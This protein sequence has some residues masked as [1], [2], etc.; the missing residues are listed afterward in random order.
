M[1]VPTQD[2]NSACPGCAERDREIADLKTRVARLE[3]GARAGKRQ[4]APFS[5]G[6]PKA[7]PKPP[8]R[9][10]G[11]DHGAH[12]HRDVPSRIDEVYD[13]PLPTCCSDT[14]CP[15]KVRLTGVAQQY[16]TEIIR[17]SVNRQ[18]NVPVGECDACHRRVQGRHPLQTSDA[19]GAAASQV[20]PDAQALIVQL[21]KE[22]GLSH[23]KVKRF[24]KAAFDM[25]L[26][27]GG[28]C[29]AMLR[30]GRRCEPAYR[31]IVRR[32]RQSSFI[33]PDETGWR[34]GGVLAWLHVA[35]GAD[36]TAYL[37]HRHRGYEAAAEL[38]GADYEGSLTHDGWSA[39]EQFVYAIH[40]TCLGHLLR[41]SKELEE[42]A[43][44]VAARACFPLAVKAVLKEALA[45]RDRRDAGELT[46]E[47]AREQAG[48]LS[49]RVVALVTPTQADADNERFAKHLWNQQ[50]AL[51]T[52]LEYGGVDATNH[53]AEQAIR[54]AVPNRK[55]SGGNRTEAGAEAQSILTSVLRT[56]VQRGI[57]S[58]SFISDTLKACLGRHP[59]IVPETG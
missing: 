11:E 54:P 3:A 5:K 56:T 43:A 40:Q 34:I 27:R 31:A 41:R 42:A 39:Y 58:L 26:S 13:V 17:T 12:R 46:A 7:D 53:K 6:P 24:F 55:V 47:Q 8:G 14:D 51:F 49:R 1:D 44:G 45:V 37:V 29:R 57:D 9:K 48:L 19:L 22:G 25:D 32:V 15:G 23:G 52:F 20:G 30:A 16:Q 18:F 35:V 4:A 28:I 59:L 2:T 21:N 38:I 33:V 50:S 10:S 36:A